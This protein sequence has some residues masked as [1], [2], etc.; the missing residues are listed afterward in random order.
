MRVKSLKFRVVVWFVTLLIP[1]LLLFSIAL[2]YFFNQNFITKQKN[3]LRNRAIDIIE[4]NI[5]TS[6]NSTELNL[7]SL[8]KLS[9]ALYQNG[10]LISK[11]PKFTKNDLKEFQK[12]S[13]S[14]FFII[15]SGETLEIYYR[16]PMRN[17]PNDVLLLKKEGVDDEVENLVDTL[18]F[19]NPLLLLLLVIA[20]YTIIEKTI[21]PIRNA[22]KMASQTAIDNLPKPLEVPKNDDEIKDLILS[23]NKMVN[24]LDDGIRQMERF[25]SDVSHELRTPLTVMQGEID[26]ALRKDRDASNLKKTLLIISQETYR[27]RELVENLLFLSRHSP[28]S[29]RK[30]FK[31]IY[32]DEILIDTI[33]Q[34]EPMLKEKN[35]NLNIERLEPSEIMSSSSLLHTLFRNLLDNA[36]KYTPKG[37]EINISIFYDKHLYFRISDEGIGIAN[38]KIK[39]I[40]ERFYR[41]DEARSRQIPG[42]GLGLSI[43]SKIVS[44]HKGKL[45][46]QSQENIGTDIEV[47]L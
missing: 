7:N 18:L 17:I 25:N 44:L 5:Q 29:I 47:I 9:V 22:S 15:D 3:H 33:H 4:K 12:H 37:K 23:F 1:I 19:L 41:V 30:N 11:S 38:D 26:I 24:R 31:P 35:L 16:Y 42:F 20:S 39:N 32:A 40:T 34:I 45:N 10:K 2:Y 27:L 21:S 43:V 6:Q 28:E 36:I 14:S 46:I 8:G 13:K